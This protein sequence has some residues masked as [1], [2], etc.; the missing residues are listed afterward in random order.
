MSDKSNLSFEE[1]LLNTMQGVL[2]DTRIALP[3][4]VLSFDG[5]KVSVQPLTKIAKTVG[6]KES[7]VEFPVIEDVPVIIPFAQSLGLSLTLPIAAGDN[8]LLIISDRELS[9]FVNGDGLTPKQPYKS[10]VFSNTR[11]RNLKDAIYIPGLSPN[12]KTLAV[13]TSHIE[14]RNKGRSIYISLGEDGIKLTDGSSELSLQGGNAM[15]KTSGNFSVECGGLFTVSSSN[16]GIASSGNAVNNSG[17]FV[18]NR[19]ITLGSHVH[20][21]VSTGNSNTSGPR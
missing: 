13:D 3:C 7:Y 17:T 11:S 6:D 8:G 20:G 1:S 21:G 10:N 15:L 16:F 12:S 14:L 4:K 2:A 18:D 9:S 19:G 5:I